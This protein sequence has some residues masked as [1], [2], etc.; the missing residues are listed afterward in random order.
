MFYESIEAKRHV[1]KLHNLLLKSFHEDLE[2]PLFKRITINHL[3]LNRTKTIATV[4]LDLGSI[5]DTKRK[6]LVLKKI[7]KLNNLFRNSLSSSLDKYR[8]PFF[9]FEEDKVFAKGQKVEQL[10][11][12]DLSNGEGN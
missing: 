1:K 10:I 12:L 3:R 7:N 6:N 5:K 4:Y 11:N 9:R 2:D 8:I